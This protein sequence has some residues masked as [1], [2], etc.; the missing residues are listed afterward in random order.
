MNFIYN[1][2][3][4]IYR[5]MKK[6]L[7]KMTLG[8]I[9]ISILGGV[10]VGLICLIDKIGIVSIFITWVLIYLSYNIGNEVYE[11]ILQLRANK[12]KGMRLRRNNKS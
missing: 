3:E 4:V 7:I 8:L 6:L 2:K 10:F 1:I 11:V 12:T 9:A 5:D